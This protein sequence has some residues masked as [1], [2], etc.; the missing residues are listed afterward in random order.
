M[1][2]HPDKFS[3][4]D[5]ETAASLND[6][7]IEMTKAYKVLT[8]E[9]VRN[10]YIMYGHPDGKQSYSIGIALPQWIVAAENTYYVLAVY[11]FLFGIV[12]PYTVGKWWYG[13]KKYTK[14]GVVTESAGG[15]FKAYDASMD[16]RMLVEILPLG[17]E[18]KDL[19]E[20][21]GN[22]GDDTEVEAK[23][24][25][26]VGEKSFKRLQDMEVGPRRRSLA[27]LW[28]YLYRVDLGSV[29]LENGI[30]ISLG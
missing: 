5:N 2:Y 25:D 20:E 4:S 26:V 11:G 16:E 14:D 18:Y 24:K 8:D 19:A 30:H 17:E 1:T 29:K 3:P 13:T 9:E 27:L 10:N 6:R 22:L 15:L 23:I 7:F 21:W 12:L 28:A